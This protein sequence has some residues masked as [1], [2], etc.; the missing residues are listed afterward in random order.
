[1]YDLVS[2]QVHMLDIECFSFLNRALE[3]EMSPILVV[4]TNRGITR[5][6]GTNYR[7]AVLPVRCAPVHSH[8]LAV[9]PAQGVAQCVGS[10]PQV[11]VSLLA[12]LFCFCLHSCKLMQAPG[13][14]VGV[15]CRAWAIP[16]CSVVS[17]SGHFAGRW[18]S[19]HVSSSAW[20]LAADRPWLD[21]QENMY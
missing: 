7:S 9:A 14:A 11:P 8:T 2:L 6:R 15:S 3:N 13:R 20:V 21:M 12:A 17:T 5:I 18:L 10:N 16:A 4:A 1:M 19:L